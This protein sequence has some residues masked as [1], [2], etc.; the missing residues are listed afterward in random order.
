MA[1]F[2]RDFWIRGTGMG[3]EVAQLHDK[4]YDDDDDDGGGNIAL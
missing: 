2:L 4:I 1:D 3:Q